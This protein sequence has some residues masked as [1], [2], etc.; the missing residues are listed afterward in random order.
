MGTFFCRIKNKSM[1]VF[2]DLYPYTPENGEV[3]IMLKLTAK[4]PLGALLTSD[5]IVFV[6]TLMD[7]SYKPISAQ[8]FLHL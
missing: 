8:E 4:F 3:N 7:D 1:A 6:C 2:Y 5:I